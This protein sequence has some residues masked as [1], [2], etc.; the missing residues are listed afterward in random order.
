MLPQFIFIFGIFVSN[1]NGGTIESKE[2]FGRL[3]NFTT[4]EDAIRAAGTFDNILDE[5]V[6]FSITRGWWRLAKDLILLS[7]RLDQDVSHAV[8]SGVSTIKRNCDELIRVLDKRHNEMPIVSPAFQWAQSSDSVF[9]NIMFGYRW[10][11]PGALSVESENVTVTETLFHFSGVGTHSQIT[12]KYLLDLTLY[13][14][15]SSNETEW[16]F[17]SVGKLMVTLKKAKKA[18]WQRL[19]KS[20]TKIENMHVWWE[21]KE[22]YKSDLDEL[23]RPGNNT[24]GTSVVETANTSHTLPVTPLNDSITQTAEKDEL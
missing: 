12:K 15:V 23:Q 9:L 17:G 8:R 3:T 21:M 19:T 14:E 18:N 20:K 11:S 4:E 10:S 7:H 6:Q 16:S 1:T 24:N 2:S 22:K 13:D 5:D